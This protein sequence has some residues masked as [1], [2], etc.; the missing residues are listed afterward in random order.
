MWWS[1][2]VQHPHGVIP[3]VNFDRPVSTIG[4]TSVT[5]GDVLVL[6]TTAA[7]NLS[8]AASSPNSIF[9]RVMQA[10]SLEAAAGICCVAMEG[11]TAS[12]KTTILA[13]FCGIA[14]AKVHWVS[15]GAEPLRGTSLIISSGGGTPGRAFTFTAA[16]TTARA[17]KARLLQVFTGLITESGIHTV[18]LNGF[19]D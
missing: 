10:T 16:P 14:Q 12:A 15:A 4:L 7:S 5:I 9:G 19:A 1:N 2:H 6:D 3:P 13:R 17:R 11:Y 18:L 8:L